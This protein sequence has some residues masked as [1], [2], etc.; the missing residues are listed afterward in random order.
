[1]LLES[2]MFHLKL[3]LELAKAELEKEGKFLRNSLYCKHITRQNKQIMQI[4]ERPILQPPKIIDQ[5]VKS[6]IK[7]LPKPQA[8][9]KGSQRE[10][11]TKAN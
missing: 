9:V 1:M 11:F 2:K 7:H 4:F 8:Y 5:K 6:I 10:L 3:D